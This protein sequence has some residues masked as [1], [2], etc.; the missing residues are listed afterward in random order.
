MITDADIAAGKLPLSN[1]KRL[2]LAMLVKRVPANKRRPSNVSD[3][4]ARIAAVAG[5]DPNG[6]PAVPATPTIDDVKGMAL[7]AVLTRLRGLPGVVVQDEGSDKE[8]VFLS[9]AENWQELAQDVLDVLY[10]SQGTSQT[11][12]IVQRTLEQYGV[13]ACGPYDE[14]ITTVG[15]RRP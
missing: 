2:A 4:A 3:I 10:E 5:T 8:R 6:V 13:R 9:T 7:D 11:Y 14:L 15:G 1:A 12:L